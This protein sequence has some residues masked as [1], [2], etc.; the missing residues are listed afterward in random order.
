MTEQEYRET[1]S[2]DESVGWDA[3]DAELE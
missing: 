2:E 1:F 3:I